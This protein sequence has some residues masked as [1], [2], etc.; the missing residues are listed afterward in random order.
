MDK[1]KP[2]DYEN[3]YKNYKEHTMKKT[4]EH[5]QVGQLIRKELKQAYPLIKF[6]VTS[7]SFAGGDSVSIRW[8]DGPTSRAVE[9]ITCE[10]VAG[11]FNA[12]EDIYEYDHD[13]QGLTVKYIILSRKMSKK[14]EEEIKLEIENKYS[15][16][17]SDERD[18]FDR[19]QC[20]PDTLV[21]REYK[22]RV[23]V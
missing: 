23:F 10:Y 8:E 7:R 16:D 15:C 19:F 3:H 22:D 4:T 12:M 9:K 13:K 21:Y 6:S 18:I 14:I 17:L 5:A 2:F 11:D 1:T 20:W